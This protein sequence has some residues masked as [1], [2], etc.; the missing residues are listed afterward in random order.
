MGFEACNAD[1][2]RI[3]RGINLGITMVPPSY[4]VLI[5]GLIYP[6]PCYYQ[7][8]IALL[9]LVIIYSCSLNADCLTAVTVTADMDIGL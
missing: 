4:A 5:G 6:A 9:L 7:G 1:L 3:F 2:L 8:V